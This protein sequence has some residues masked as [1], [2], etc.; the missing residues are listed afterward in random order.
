[1]SK[2]NI[3]K[4]FWKVKKQPFSYKLTCGPYLAKDCHRKPIPKWLRNYCQ[5]GTLTQHSFKIW[6]NSPQDRG[7]RKLL[8]SIHFPLS[9][10]HDIPL[11]Q[12]NY[13]DYVTHSSTKTP[14][15]TSSVLTFLQ[16]PATR[17]IYVCFMTEIHPSAD[18]PDPKQ[19]WQE[20]QQ[21]INQK[22]NIWCQWFS[23]KNR[24]L[25]RWTIA[26]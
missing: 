26:I 21:K 2:K 9:M 16:R 22:E 23:V 12:Q 1:M 14:E 25:R 13:R 6:L 19:T 18:E 10:S 15:I 20:S 11:P 24:S 3:R 4:L 8:H 17:S 5:S 7:I